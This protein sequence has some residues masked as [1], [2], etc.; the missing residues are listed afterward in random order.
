MSSDP[1]PGTLGP[2]LRC[3]PGEIDETCLSQVF[4][5]HPVGIPLG[6]PLGVGVGYFIAL[7]SV[8]GRSPSD[9]DCAL[10]FDQKPFEFDDCLSHRL[11]GSGS[12]RKNSF[13]CC[14]GVGE[15]GVVRSR[16]LSLPEDFHGAKDS[17]ELR[18]DLSSRPLPSEVEKD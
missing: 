1:F 4:W 2:G 12:V 15:D 3:P 11:A 9:G 14:R 17:T 10:P 13:N 18:A 16:F 5:A 8:V 6:S 7:Y